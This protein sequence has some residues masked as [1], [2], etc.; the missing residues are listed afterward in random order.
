MDL[1]LALLLVLG[2]YTLGAASHAGVGEGSPVEHAG[3]AV[4][5]GA[6]VPVKTHES[7]SVGSEPWHDCDTDRHYVIY[8]DLSRSPSPATDCG[9]ACADE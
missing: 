8:R 1:L 3:A 2:G 7:V 6:D 9:A 4:G 5:A